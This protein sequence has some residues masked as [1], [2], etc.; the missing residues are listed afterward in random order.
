MPTEPLSTRKVLL[1]VLFHVLCDSVLQESSPDQEFIAKV[2]EQFSRGDKK[3]P[4]EQLHFY[5]SFVFFQ[6]RSTLG[7]FCF[8][9]NGL[10]I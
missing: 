9:M 3:L 5:N 1:S 8:Y 6:S 10:Q 4:L 7:L 2:P